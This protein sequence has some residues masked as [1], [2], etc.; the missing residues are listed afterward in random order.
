MNGMT[1]HYLLHRTYSVQPGDTIVVHAATG[2]MGLILCQWAK[3]LGA[4][5][6]GTVSTPEKAEVARAAGCDHPVVR[7]ERNFVDAVR[8]VTEGKGCA[9]VDEAIG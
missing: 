2:G 4:T 9:V 1:A 3:A 5:I 7:Y 6:F 8:D